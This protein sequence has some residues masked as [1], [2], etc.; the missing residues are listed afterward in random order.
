VKSTSQLGALALALATALSL[1]LSTPVAAQSADEVAARRAFRLGEAH[2]R[3]GEFQ[4]AGELFEEA[5][6]LSGRVR[7]MFNAYLAY[8]DL[9]DLPNAS[10][11]LR[12]F[13]EAGTDVPQQERD[14][15]TARLEAMERAMARSA[16]PPTA[17]QPTTAQPTTAQPTAAQP[18]AE[19]TPATEPEAEPRSDAPAATGTVAAD[20]D[21]APPPEAADEDGGGFSPSP[22]GFIVGGVGLALV[23][24]G[25]GVGVASSGN[26]S[27]LE[28]RCPG[29]VCPDDPE[30]RSTQSTG[31]TLALTADILWITGAAATITG[32]VLI[33]VLQDDAESDTASARIGGACTLDGCFASVEGSF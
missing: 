24:A 20:A 27:T 14:Q 2:Y 32:V 31:E 33:F 29:D 6:R 1:A 8:R 22:I 23:G 15:L 21:E 25:I 3:N 13:L 26:L 28:D 17:A 10:R 9:Q 18:I 5:Y 11:T 19:E 16:A 4:R 30:L 7:L 12:V